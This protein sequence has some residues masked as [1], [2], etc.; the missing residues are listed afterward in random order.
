[1]IVQVNSFCVLF[2][3]NIGV[4]L[5]DDDSEDDTYDDRPFETHREREGK[6][7]GSSQGS[8]QQEATSVTSEH[9]RRYRPNHARHRGS[10]HYKH[11]YKRHQSSKSRPKT[12]P[13]AMVALPGE[14]GEDD[15]NVPVICVSPPAHQKKTEVLGKEILKPNKMFL[16]VRFVWK[17]PF[18]CTL[19]RF[20][21]TV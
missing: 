2:A 14:D 20:W 15:A 4:G 12:V 10:Y 13:K 18:K 5:Q 17:C 16:I 8:S 11:H 19:H 3:E 9:G 21:S 6:E 1:M 7:D